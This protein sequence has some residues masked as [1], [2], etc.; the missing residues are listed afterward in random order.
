M[1]RSSAIHAPPV[2]ELNKIPANMI[3]DNACGSTALGNL[4]TSRD[5]RWLSHGAPLIQISFHRGI[6]DL[7]AWS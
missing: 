7:A 5:S 2:T 1:T 4:N 3:V 6:I